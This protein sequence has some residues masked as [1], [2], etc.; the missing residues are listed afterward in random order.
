[1][2]GALYDNE[3]NTPLHIAAGGYFLKLDPL[4]AVE[5][6]V[7][8]GANINQLNNAGNTALD[9]AIIRDNSKIIDFL[10]RSGAVPGK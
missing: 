9:L 3:G 8:N 1:L 6:L 10:K 7:R 4:E 2:P 5:Y